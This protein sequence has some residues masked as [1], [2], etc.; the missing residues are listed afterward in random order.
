[1]WP[2]SHTTAVSSCYHS[3]VLFQP[4]ARQFF[5]FHAHRDCFGFRFDAELLIL[6]ALQ[7][8][9]GDILQDATE[10]YMQEF[11]AARAGALSA[12]E[13]AFAA[14]QVY[15]LYHVEAALYVALSLSPI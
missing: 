8:V 4:S 5:G 6:V 2:H 14:V 13:G 11:G 9:G 3:C 12:R 7:L 15:E 1:M 10:I